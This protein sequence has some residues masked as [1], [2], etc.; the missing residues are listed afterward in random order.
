M[1][2]S[3]NSSVLFFKI[4]KFVFFH[5]FFN[6]KLIFD[7]GDISTETQR[8]GKSVVLNTRFS[9]QN[10]FAFIRGHSKGIKWILEDLG[11]SSKRHKKGILSSPQKMLWHSCALLFITSQ[12]FV[13]AGVKTFTQNQMFTESVVNGLRSL[14]SEGFKQ[15]NILLRIDLFHK[16]R[17]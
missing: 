1:R 12:S 14:S 7:K 4:L 2:F 5:Y 3:G 9:T 10:M 8:T 13:G 17:A 15:R 11:K 6:I 16:W